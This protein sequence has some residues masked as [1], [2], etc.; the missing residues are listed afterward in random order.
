MITIFL[1]I[2]IVPALI[3]VLYIA[4]RSVLS[5]Q[6][7]DELSRQLA[8]VDIAAFRN[9]VDPNETL[10][11]REKLAPAAFRAVQRQRQIAALAY[12]KAVAHNAALLIAM[13]NPAR[14]SPHP[15]VASTAQ[16]V[17]EQALQLRIR[18]LLLILKLWAG[19]ALPGL[20]VAGSSIV[21]RYQSVSSGFVDFVHL[22]RPAGTTDPLGSS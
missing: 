20:S 4:R 13:A 15:E 22:S 14:T 6:S 9:L 17:V 1:V 3:F 16:K 10:Y 11:L 12:V 18:S 5:G 7:Y 19:I 2:G 21:D 8:P